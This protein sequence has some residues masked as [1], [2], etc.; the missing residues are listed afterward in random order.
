MDAGGA[1]VKAVFGLTEQVVFIKR[2]P[3]VPSIKIGDKGQV[4]TN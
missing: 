2:L 3:P 4:E 1:G